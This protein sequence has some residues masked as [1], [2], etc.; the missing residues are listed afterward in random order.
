MKELVFFFFFFCE[1]Q[2]YQPCHTDMIP[3]RAPMVSEARAQPLLSKTRLPWYLFGTRPEGA[4]S[5]HGH[6]SEMS[7]LPVL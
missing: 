3:K 5:Q 2:D 1:S 4:S 7:L 6:L